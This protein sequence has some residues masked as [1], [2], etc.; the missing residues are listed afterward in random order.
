VAAG[1]EGVVAGGDEVMV[2]G[3]E[4]VMVAGEEEVVAV[5]SCWTTSSAGA[6]TEITDDGA[7]GDAISTVS[8]W[9]MKHEAITDRCVP[10]RWAQCKTG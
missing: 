10:K 7:H 4:E 9:G 5:S 6:D 8:E 3:G 1:E 2:A